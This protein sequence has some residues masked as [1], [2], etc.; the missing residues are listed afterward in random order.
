MELLGTVRKN[1][2]GSTESEKAAGSLR[3]GSS[4]GLGW[5]LGHGCGQC[6]G[7]DNTREAAELA[8][9]GCARPR[10]MRV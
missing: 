7:G 2:V 6:R 4:V 5:T 10:E 1:S 9:Q 8:Q 3:G